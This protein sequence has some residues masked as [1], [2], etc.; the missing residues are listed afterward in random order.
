MILHMPYMA[1]GITI[2][3]GEA[4]NQ[5]CY[6]AT[7]HELL[8]SALAVKMAHDIDPDNFVSCMLATGN[9]YPYS[10]RLEDVMEAITK[11]RENYYFTDIQVRGCYPSY[12]LKELEHLGVKI[13][14]VQD[15]KQI[16]KDG[17]VDFVSFSY[18]SSMVASSDENANGGAKRN[19]FAS[20]ENPYLSSSK[21]GWQIDPL[22]H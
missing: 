6:Q 10:C 7:H 19:I 14:F 8:V 17:T 15:G 11:D 5:I 3:E 22:G 20:I 9:A 13:E 12:A 16:L 18:Y 21:W 2:H 4:R 1:A